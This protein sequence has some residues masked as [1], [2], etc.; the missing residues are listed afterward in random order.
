MLTCA[1]QIANDLA[2]FHHQ[3]ALYFRSW[4]YLKKI[5]GSLAMKA[6]TNTSV[7]RHKIPPDGIKIM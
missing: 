3:V 6:E 5:F 2:F 1:D 7:L 4:D